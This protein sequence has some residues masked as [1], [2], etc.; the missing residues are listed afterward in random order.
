MR[1]PKWTRDALELALVLLCTVRLDGGMATLRGHAAVKTAL[2]SEQTRELHACPHPE[3]RRQRLHIA[4]R[5]R[6]WV[7]QD[8]DR[9]LPARIAIE[10]AMFHARLRTERDS[11]MAPRAAPRAR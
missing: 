2:E 1:A 8:L 6:R 3:L 7:H 5:R 11:Y 10:R 4:Y 9:A